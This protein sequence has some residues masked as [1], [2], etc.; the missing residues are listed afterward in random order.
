MARTARR[1]LICW[2]SVQRRAHDCGAADLSVL[3][4][5][6][7]PLKQVRFIPA[8]Y[9]RVPFETEHSIHYMAVPR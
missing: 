5:L 9:Q 4:F 7:G 1:E 3:A 8:R 6:D 2:I